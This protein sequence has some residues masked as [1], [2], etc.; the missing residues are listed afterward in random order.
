MAKHLIASNAT[1]K[2]IK[3]GDIR[4][5]LNDGDGLCLL[6]FVKGGSHSWR[7]DY[8]FDRRRKTVSFGTY[9]ATPLSL[10]RRLADEARQQ[11]RHGLDP[12]DVRK[13][14]RRASEQKRTDERRAGQGL[15]PTGSFEEVAREWFEKNAPNWA[16]PLREDHPAP[17]AR[18]L[19]L[20]RQEADRIDPAW[21]PAGSASTGGVTR[22]N[23]NDA[24]GAAKLRSSLSIRR[25]DR[26]CRKR[27][28]PRPARCPD[29]ME[30]AAL[31]NV[32]G[33]SRGWP[34]AARHR[35]S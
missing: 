32:D 22:R 7:F 1:I 34:S 17:R 18:R 20:D 11:V 24:S 16:Y 6:L 23:R 3:P 30:T 13:A 29:A 31:C 10:A 27:S 2:A 4:S 25:R 12:S 21:R 26:T 19:P 33:P 8:T 5:R 9:P 15:P 28:E 35:R 14:S